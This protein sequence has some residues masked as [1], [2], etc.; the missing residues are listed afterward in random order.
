M[1]TKISISLVLIST[2][3]FSCST[4]K[5]TL[6]SRSYHNL[7]AKYNVYFNGKESFKKGIETIEEKNVDNY[8]DILPVFLFSEEN[9][10]AATGDMDRAILKASKLIKIH[11][12]TTK[13]KAK[14]G[15]L[16]PR[17]KA[18]YAKKEYCN[19]VDDAYLLMGKSYFV[20]RDFYQ[21]NKNF[22]YLITEYKNHPIK[23]NAILWLAQSKC[24]S[25]SLE[26]AQGILNK[27]KE[28][29]KQPEKLQDEFFAIQSD[30]YIR[31][32]KYEEAIPT[33]IKAI[34]L[35]PKRKLK[36]RYT[37]ILAQLYQVTSDKSKAIEKYEEVL[38]MNPKYEMAFNAKINIATAFDSN[39]GNSSE[40]R[41]TLSKLLKDDKNIE[42]RDQIYFAL[43][44]IA[45][46]EKKEKEAIEYYKLSIETSAGNDYQKA[47][48]YLAIGD[49]YFNKNE[50]I[51]SQPYI[52]SCARSLPE[53]YRRYNEI[54]LRSKA[55]NDLADNH[56]IILEQDSLQMVAMMDDKERQRFIDKIIEEKKDREIRKKEQE[57]LEQER[58]ANEA[59]DLQFHAPT[60]KNQT[61]YFYNKNNL[62]LGAAEFQ[63]RWGKRT[64]EDDWRRK[65]KDKSSWDASD[66]EFDSDSAATQASDEN[67]I[68]HYLSDLPLTDSAMLVSNAMIQEALLNKGFIFTYRL[69]DADQAI[70]SFLEIERRFPNDRTIVPMA[71]YYLISL[72]QNSGNNRKADE[73]KALLLNKYSDTKFAQAIANPNF[74]KEINAR[75]IRLE[76]L[77]KQAYKQYL[78]KDYRGVL[79]TCAATDTAETENYL[80]AKFDML[81]ALSKGKLQGLKTMKLSLESVVKEH[82]RKP[83][84]DLAKDILAH[85]EK[86]GMEELP[87][88][89][90]KLHITDTVQSAF[91]SF[92][93][94]EADVEIYNFEENVQHIYAI[95][96]K[97]EFVDV[98][99]LVFNLRGYN[100]DYF[101]NFDF[102]ISTRKIS[103]TISVV[104]VKYLS[105]RQQ[106]MNYYELVNLTDEV[107]KEIDKD[108]VDHFII[109][110]KN[111]TKLA[112]DKRLNKYMDFFYE[113]YVR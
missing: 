96:A 57:A 34:E 21:A 44:N 111:L 61:W 10:S 100:L 104:T 2:L 109:T 65:D 92:I 88:D 52:D 78:L 18:F 9:N 85:I 40:I 83:V 66:E 60:E 86:S 24:E 42:F 32:E 90:I 108:F 15:D 94:E 59:S 22:E 107:Y 20:K 112:A 62:A 80:K 93:A 113:Y 50:F 33:L 4:E 69:I 6:S 28:E 76:K 103:E 8:N 13:P 99:R 72:Y 17:Q 81:E 5:N 58:L 55:L 79:E 101:S 36:K 49:I 91:S 53:D 23:H 106:A 12:I 41:N 48:S 71:Y 87:K 82:E 73:Y 16:S 19:W 68:D 110:D 47:L 43:A 3:L 35:T 70:E 7:T 105:D 84:A 77:Y 63:K 54:V 95:A 97:T 45:F 102:E 39:T 30:V 27:I 14:G 38:Q 46:E 37:Y 75:E 64:L 89:T 25:G 98:N 11:S 56:K 1:N 74:I 67:S 26:D 29:G 31:Q 51:K